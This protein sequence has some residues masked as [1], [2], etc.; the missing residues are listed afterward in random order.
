MA[1]N[2]WQPFIDAWFLF[3]EKRTGIPPK[4]DGA[5]GKAL[6]QIKSYLD[7][8]STGPPIDSW[9]YILNNWERLDTWTQGQLDL[10]VINS[11]FNIIIN[12]LKNGKQPTGQS[13]TAGGLAAKIAAFYSG[14]GQR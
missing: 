5:Q 8:V 14:N 11:K 12:T 4:F 1:V 7:K 9:N 2:S 10:K 3:Y 6:K 13:V